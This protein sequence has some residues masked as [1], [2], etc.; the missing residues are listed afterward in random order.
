MQTFLPY[1]NYLKSAQCLDDK[2]LWKQCVE[3]L[4]IIQVLTETTSKWTN[5]N[6]WKNHPAVKMWRG[7]E[8]DLQLYGILCCGVWKEERNGNCGSVLDKIESY[9]F[10][11][12]PPY[13][14]I[15]SW[16]GHECHDILHIQNKLHYSHQCNLYRKDPEYYGQYFEVKIL[17][18]EQ[19]YYWPVI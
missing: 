2:R 1:P 17:K 6:A 11:R 5:P 8:P 16:L 13:C 3:C 12:K 15:P 7:F 9:K 19:P 4:Q 14:G 10:E 18:K